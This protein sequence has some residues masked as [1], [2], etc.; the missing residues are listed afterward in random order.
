MHSQKSLQGMKMESKHTEWLSLFFPHVSSSTRGRWG[1][2]SRLWTFSSERRGFWITQRTNY[3]CVWFDPCQICGST[4]AWWFRRCKYM[5]SARKSCEVRSPS[6]LFQPRPMYTSD[7]HGLA[8][9]QNV[10]SVLHVVHKKRCSCTRPGEDPSASRQ[11][12]FSVVFCD[13]LFGERAQTTLWHLV[14]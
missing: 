2:Y 13:L 5:H 1:K 4:T 3:K 14:F 9:V 10:V 7:A 6:G 12:S 11:T 8:C